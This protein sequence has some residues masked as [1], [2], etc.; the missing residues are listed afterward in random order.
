MR[1]K[2]VLLLPLILVSLYAPCQTQLWTGILSPEAT[3]N[4]TATTTP[5]KCAMDW[6]DYVGIPGGLPDASWTQ[7]GSTIQASTYGN[8]S[9]DASAG[10]QTALNACSGNKYVLL[11]AGTFL[12]SA[13]GVRVPAGC[14]LRGAGANQTII[15]L[16]AASAAVTLGGGGSPNFGAA[17]AISNANAGGNTLTVASASGLSVGQ[18]LVIDQLNDNVIVSSTGTEGACTWCDGETSNGSRAQGQIDKITN[19]SGTTITLEMPL[20]VNYTLTPHAAPLSMATNAGLENLQI[21]ANGSGSAAQL[22]F[23]ACANCWVRGVEGNYAAGDHLDAD[24]SYR[25]NIVDSYFSNAYMHS[26]GCCDSDVDLRYKTTGFLIQNNIFER[27]HVSIMLEWGASGNV[28]AYNYSSGNFDAGSTNYVMQDVD[29]HGAHP[30][31]NLFEGNVAATVGQDGIWG[32]AAN[33]TAFRNWAQGTTEICSPATAGRSTV[34]NC[35]GANGWIA[36]QAAKAFDV[37]APTTNYFMIGNVE[38]STQQATLGT[39]HALA[40]ALCGTTVPS[41][42]PCGADSRIY[43]GDF[44]NETFGYGTTGDTGSQ[45][46][47]NDTPWNTAFIHGEF[48]SVANAITWANGITHTL[49]AS[50]YLSSQPSWWTSGIP[51]PAIGPDVAGGSGPGGHVYSTTAGNPAM[52]CY[53]NVIGATYGGAGSPYSFNADT[54]YPT[55]PVAAAPNPPTDL[56]AIVQ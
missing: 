21:Y 4:P 44:Y 26:P 30:Q 11:G 23:T 6:Q 38:G 2:L 55:G 32:S 15:N 47:D 22:Q 24:W 53:Y 9:S 54:C 51:W 36:P 43:Q 52:N 17:T 25:G 19:I 20:M 37:N 56:T 49:P 33:N 18:F 10:I 50:F 27:L 8:G 46:I 34:S 41:G 1:P 5:S 40:I 13:G 14:V 12:F 45:S 39:G 28:I 42:V 48:S 3:C 7:S 16:K 29:F 35:T 31:F